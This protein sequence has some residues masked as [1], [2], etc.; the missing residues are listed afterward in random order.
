[1]ESGKLG[2]FVFVGLFVVIALSALAMFQAQGG[3]SVFDPEKLQGVLGMAGMMAGIAGGQT[4]GTIGTG[5][6]QT[7]GESKQTTMTL[8]YYCDVDEDGYFSK[9]PT[10]CSGASCSLLSGCTPNKPNANKADCK[11]MDEKINPGAKE[12]EG[13]NID[14]NCD[15]KYTASSG[16]TS[17]STGESDQSGTTPPTTGVTYIYYCDNDK[18]GDYG[19]TQYSTKA[20]TI[21]S[22]CT[23]SVPVYPDCDDSNSNIHIGALEICDGID[24]DCDKFID[25]E[26]SVGCTYYYY[27]GDQ[28][29][30][31]NFA[32]SVCKCSKP[33]SS[34]VTNSG[35]CQDT[36]EAVH[37]NQIE[38]CNQKDD[39]CNGQVDEGNVCGSTT[40]YCDE[41]HDGYTSSVAHSCTGSNCIPSYCYSFTTTID[42]NDNN[43]DVSPSK[44]ETCNGIDDNCDGVID[45]QDSN[46]CKTYFYD[47]DQDGYGTTA[48]FCLCAPTGSYTATK[49]GDCNSNTAEANPGMME[50]CDG[51]D[52]D[53]DGLTDEEGAISC[54][55]YYYDYDKD[56]WGTDTF[57]CL[58]SAGGN[59]KSTIYYTA[60]QKVDCNDNNANVHPG[61]KEAYPGKSEANCVNHLDDDCDGKVDGADPDCQVP[62]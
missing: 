5:T 23:K 6:S 33:G 53:C 4:T 15:G 51:I 19:S 35:D 2:L 20:T 59:L 36:Q 37:P 56:T 11:D 61:Q 26:N 32:I 55:V 43:F 18:D 47:G 48:S 40:Y 27:D 3:V 9:Y 31:G 17:G 62:I 30:Y 39:N 58:C 25:E 42:C 34:Y 16:T 45:P 41:D 21:P 1:M 38:S 44:T 13:N 29:G 46:N 12:I 24:N 52:N 8:V 50:K 60:T 10:S 54:T 49:T 28:D 14:E 22:Y 57:K 7:I